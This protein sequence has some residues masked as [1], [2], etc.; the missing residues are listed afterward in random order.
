MAALTASRVT[1][2]TLFSPLITRD[3][4]MA[5]TPARAATSLMVGGRF[6][7][8]AGVISIPL[9]VQTRKPY[10]RGIARG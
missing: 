7:R 4:V 6:R 1:G 9:S 3:T 8:R 2:R 10:R 5:E